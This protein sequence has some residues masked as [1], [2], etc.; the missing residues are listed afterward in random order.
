MYNPESVLEN[1]THKII[2][3]FLIQMD[4]LISARRSDQVIVNKGKRT[5]Q[6][7]DFALSADN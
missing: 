5:C 7:I 2:W 3:D 4:P 1:E 6:I